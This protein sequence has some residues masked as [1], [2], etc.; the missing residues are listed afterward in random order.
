MSF[1]VMMSPQA[2][3]A[4]RHFCAVL[5][6][7]HAASTLLEPS[8][9]PTLHGLAAFAAEFV[10]LDGSRSRSAAAGRDDAAAG[11]SL[12]SG[13]ES[14]DGGGSEEAPSAVGRGLAVGKDASLGP[15]GWNE[16]SRAAGG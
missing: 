7:L 2:L 1:P 13:L 5:F 12:S 15:V 10:A 8:R 3:M 6:R 9:F 11:G 4:C 14:A 16:V